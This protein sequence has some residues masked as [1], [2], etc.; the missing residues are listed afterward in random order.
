MLVSAPCRSDNGFFLGA[1]EVAVW[2]ADLTAL[3]AAV[4]EQIGLLD[5]EERARAAR[6]RIA[7]DRR[8]FIA[9]HALARVLIGRYLGRAPDSLRFARAPYG[10]PYVENST[11]EAEL[12]FNASRTRGRAVFAF[13]LAREVGIDVERVTDY[14]NL[15]TI[16]D[17]V[18]SPSE[19]AMLD[20]VPTEVAQ[21][22][23]FF[24][25]WARKEAI[26]KARGLGLTVA[27]TAVDAAT[28]AAWRVEQL[29]LEH[30]FAAA[31]AAE[32]SN[33]RLNSVQSCTRHLLCVG[34]I[35]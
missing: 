21:R 18:L 32:G 5:A 25:A 34:G 2:D 13:A 30:P 4:S 10:K 29:A 22:D 12:R 15:S 17:R 35:E 31:I 9:A 24:A 3:A 23:A 14:S 19:K 33:W 28:S 20:A 6:L 26:L 27:P 11:G 7:E 16:F 8:Q 1:N